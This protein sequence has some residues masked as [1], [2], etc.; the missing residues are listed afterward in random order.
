MSYCTLDE[1]KNQVDE[2][3]LVQ[4]TDDEG[5]GAVSEIRVTQAIQDADDEIDG[6]LGVR[7]KVPL[8]PVPEAVRRLAVDITVYNLYSRREKIPEH[9]SERYKN[10]VRFLE[11]IAAGKISLGVSD[12]EGTPLDVNRTET[13]D[14][15]PERAFTRSSLLGF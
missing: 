4:L 3:R 15:N 6:Y 14:E 8:V 5:A 13:A 9:R 1:V 2:L 12:P 11:G 7:M 10:A